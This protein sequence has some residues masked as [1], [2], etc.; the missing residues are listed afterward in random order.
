MR[1]AVLQFLLVP[2]AYAVRIGVCQ[3]GACSRNGGA[4]LL[5]AA[6]ALASSQRSIE[7]AGVPCS[8]VCPSRAVVVHAAKQTLLQATDVEQALE[9][10]TAALTAYGC[11]VPA[12]LVKSFE[13]MKRAEALL[14]AGKASEAEGAYTAALSSRP[15][16]TAPLQD[17]LPP[18]PAEWEGSSWKESR[19][20]SELTFDDSVTTFEFGTCADGE[21]LLTGCTIGGDE[22][23]VLTGSVEGAHVVGDVEIRMAADGRSFSGQL[24]LEDGTEEAWSGR[25]ITDVQYDEEVPAD[26]RWLFHC[27]VGRATALIQ[28]GEA[29]RALVDARD[30]TQLCCRAPDGWRVRAE[31]A[32]ASEDGEEEAASARREL[33]CLLGET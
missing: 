32:E 9:S 1:G 20:G 7:V 6:Q 24:R 2:G 25:R 18:E 26:G 23:Y 3:G 28:Q 11:E 27:L 15:M 12:A 21:M 4:L 10:A 16:I 8:S 30:A 22:D 13:A 5:E 14:A 31:A 19:F 33:A 29:E 17:P